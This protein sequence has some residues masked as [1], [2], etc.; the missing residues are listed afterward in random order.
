MAYNKLVQVQCKTCLL[1]PDNEGVLEAALV[2]DLT[3]HIGLEVLDEG[4]PR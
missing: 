4:A 2:Q 3:L 1:Q